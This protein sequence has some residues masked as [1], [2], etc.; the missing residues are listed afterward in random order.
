ML[1]CAIR[2]LT[3][4]LCDVLNIFFIIICLLGEVSTVV[5]SNISS[6]EDYNNGTIIWLKYAWKATM[7]ISI[8]GRNK[9]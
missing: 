8:L 1:K 6:P 5:L 7:K 3:L 4:F 9:L 2:I